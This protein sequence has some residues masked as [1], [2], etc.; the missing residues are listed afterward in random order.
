MLSTAVLVSA[1]ASFLTTSLTCPAVAREQARQAIA[2]REQQII[3]H[4][5][6]KLNQIRSELEMSETRPERIEALIDAAL[7]PATRMAP[8]PAPLNPVP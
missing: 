1:A 8:K 6:P 2:L 5:L 7:E 4:Y 3:Q